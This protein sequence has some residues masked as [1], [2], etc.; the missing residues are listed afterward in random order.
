MIK[1][2]LAWLLMPIY[3]VLTMTT[4]CV[5]DVLLKIL[6]PI[7]RGIH[8]LVLDTGVHLL[9]IHLRVLGTRIHVTFA[10]QLPVERPLV[11][12][13][14][15]QSVFDIPLLMW[16]L[17]QHSPVFVAKRE[18]GKWIPSVSCTL[19]GNGSV[20]IDRKDPAQAIP[21]IRALGADIQNRKIA[22]CIFPEGT[23]ARDG[24]MKKFKPSGLAVLLESA[25][26]A[27]IVPVVISGSW[28]L[29][30]HS[31]MPIPLGTDIFFDVL[32]PIEKHN[33]P[34]SELISRVESQIRA[35]VAARS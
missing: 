11:V 23:R 16:Y 3:I 35:G 20:L 13:S 29:F 7:H 26:D 4:L 25:P 31:L 5:W 33:T 10:A 17:H 12:I 32:A 1:K 28:K 22:A 2:L 9:L 6:F 34:P 14:N 21:A 15:H 8:K 27:L 30:Q 24:K 19:R 18:L